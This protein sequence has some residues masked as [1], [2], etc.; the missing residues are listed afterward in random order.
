VLDVSDV[1]GI[2]RERVRGVPSENAAAQ[3]VLLAAAPG[4][5]HAVHIEGYGVVGTAR[6]LG[7]VA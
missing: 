1:D 6:D 3:L 2:G 7:D 4:P 5:D